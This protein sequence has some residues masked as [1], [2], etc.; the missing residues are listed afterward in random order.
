MS[1]LAIIEHDRGTLTS[2]SLGVLTAARNLAQQMNT[3]MHST[4]SLLSTAQRL[5]TKRITR[6]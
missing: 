4:P 6:H 5:F 2:A 3:T 1:V